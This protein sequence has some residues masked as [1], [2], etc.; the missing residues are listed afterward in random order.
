MSDDTEDAN[1]DARDGREWLLALL[2]D[3]IDEAHRKVESGRVYDAENEKVRIK[4]INALARIAK[5]RNKVANDRDLEELTER[6]EA[7]EER[8]EGGR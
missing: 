3:A 7:L 8:Q 2:D 1:A 6:L 4:W 5:A